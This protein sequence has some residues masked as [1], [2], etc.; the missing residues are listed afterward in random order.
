MSLE[1]ITIVGLIRLLMHK[2]AVWT[3]SLFYLVLISHVQEAGLSPATCVLT[4]RLSIED[5]GMGST[6][7]C[8]GSTACC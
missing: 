2:A 5:G 8:R 4:K 7:R 1:T 6:V 3:Y